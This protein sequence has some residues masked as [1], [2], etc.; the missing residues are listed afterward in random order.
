MDQLILIHRLTSGILLLLAI[1]YY[2]CEG[3]SL[4]RSVTLRTRENPDFNLADCVESICI[5][6]DHPRRRFLWKRK[7]ASSV[8][9]NISCKTFVPGRICKMGHYDSHMV[10][11]DNAIYSSRRNFIHCGMGLSFGIRLGLSNWNV[12]HLDL[13]S[14]GL[15]YLPNG[16]FRHFTSLKY[17][18]LSNNFITGYDQDFILGLSNLQN[19]D[20][21]SNSLTEMDF[22]WINHNTTLEALIL[23]SN[24]ISSVRSS[25]RLNQ[26]L[27][28][29]LSFNS[30]ALMSHWKFS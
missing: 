25:V 6:C 29:D 21:S 4:N 18:N 2:S 19:L 1:A 13:S 23:S 15:T 28:I 3:K 9:H 24:R 20:L 14:S 22:S 11:L 27:L 5:Y 30:L 17:L 8:L 16:I 10:T 12:K 7:L 26:S